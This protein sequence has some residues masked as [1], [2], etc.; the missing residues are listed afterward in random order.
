MH[1]INI[2]SDKFET[3]FAINNINEQ[4][5]IN[6]SN[7][8]ISDKAKVVL[9]LGQ[10]FNLPNNVVGK[11]RSIFSELTYVKWLRTKQFKYSNQ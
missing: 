5:L 7:T 4:W 11:E 1:N 3:N 6:L 8:E 2:C 10:Q 9:Q